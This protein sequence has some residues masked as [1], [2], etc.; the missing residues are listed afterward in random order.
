MELLKYNFFFNVCSNLF[1]PFSFSNFKLKKSND[2][3]RTGLCVCVCVCVNVYL[4]KFDLKFMYVLSV[5]VRDCKSVCLPD[6]LQCCPWG[7]V[8]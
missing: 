2:E 3:V 4:C 5:C 8:K 1:E 7:G 6:S